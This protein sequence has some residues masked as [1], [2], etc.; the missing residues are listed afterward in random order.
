VSWLCSFIDSRNDGGT[1][2]GRLDVY[3]RPPGMPGASP[4]IAVDI[5]VPEISGTVE[6]GRARIEQFLWRY[7]RPPCAHIR[8]WY[9]ERD[10]ETGR[11]RRI[12]RPRPLAHLLV[13]DAAPETLRR[14]GRA[15]CGADVGADDAGGG[16]RV[17]DIRSAVYGSLRAAQEALGNGRDLCAACFAP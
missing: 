16:G 7:T 1:T 13:A 2:D 10:R 8:V 15:K 14:L 12:A 3:L 9:T 6:K 11:D 5:D 17:G 4:E